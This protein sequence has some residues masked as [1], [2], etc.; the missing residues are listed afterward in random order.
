MTIPD[1]ILGYIDS[2][3]P[4]TFTVKD[5]VNYLYSETEQKHWSK[6]QKTQI[7]NSIGGKLS[8]YNKRNWKRVKIGVY[9]P[10]TNQ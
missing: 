5:V 1:T 2:C 3:Q 8:Y 6:Q 7:I 10:I 4:T 9:K